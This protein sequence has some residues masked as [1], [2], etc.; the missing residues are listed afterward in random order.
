MMA[1]LRNSIESY[2]LEGVPA[3]ADWPAETRQLRAEHRGIVAAIASGDA[4]TA[5]T[6]VHS[7]I[8]GYYALTRL[9]EQ[10]PR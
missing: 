10:D 6:R 3:I 2:V 1:G 4:A 5:Q 9:T 7:H 8:T